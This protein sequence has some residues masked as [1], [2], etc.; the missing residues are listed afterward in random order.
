M[1]RGSYCFEGRTPTP[2]V[3][4]LLLLPV[5]DKVCAACLKVILFKEEG[6]AATRGGAVVRFGF[7]TEGAVTEGVFDRRSEWT[8]PSQPVASHL[9][10]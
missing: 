7:G 4:L 3:L 1:T 9:A 8:F 10:V 2:T 5:R 6:A